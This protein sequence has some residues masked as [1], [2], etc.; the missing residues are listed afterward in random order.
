MAFEQNAGA[1]PLLAVGTKVDLRWA[2]EH[3]IVLDAGQDA[4]AGVQQVVP[5]ARPAAEVGA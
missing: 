5:A 3:S 4:D 1:R 2:V